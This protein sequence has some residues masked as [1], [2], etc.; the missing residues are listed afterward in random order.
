MCLL[1]EVFTGENQ[2]C[3]TLSFS[4]KLFS[5]KEVAAGLVTCVGLCLPKLH[6]VTLGFCFFGCIFLF[7]NCRGDGR[8]RICVNRSVREQMSFTAVCHMR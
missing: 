2:R 4:L 7:L 5:L 1:L 3:T 6:N 8:S